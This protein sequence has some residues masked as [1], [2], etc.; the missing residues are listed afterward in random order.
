MFCKTPDRR[1]SICLYT[2]WTSRL[3]VYHLLTRRAETLYCLVFLAGWLD[4]WRRALGSACLQ[5]NAVGSAGLHIHVSA[6]LTLGALQHIFLRNVGCC[7]LLETSSCWPGNA[8]PDSGILMS[9]KEIR[10]ISFPSSF[11]HFLEVCSH[12]SWG[13]V[14]RNHIFPI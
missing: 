10:N 1:Y 4:Y 3:E 11:S 8:V 14:I 6:W 7:A 12:W 13:D 9:P 5:E 2:Y